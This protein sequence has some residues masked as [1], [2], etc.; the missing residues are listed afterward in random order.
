MKAIYIAFGDP[1]KELPII[2]A[3]KC[4]IGRSYCD[5]RRK[6]FKVACKYF[7]DSHMGIYLEASSKRISY[8]FYIIDIECS[9]NTSV[10]YMRNL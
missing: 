4:P 9:C 7:K 2:R 1:K 10:V 6:P 3:P 5:I 8:L